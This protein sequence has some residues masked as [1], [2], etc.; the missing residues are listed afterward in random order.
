LSA[1]AREPL[2]V[3]AA[4]QVTGKEVR[5]GDTGLLWGDTL[6]GEMNHRDAQRACDAM[7][8]SSGR[9]EGLKWRLPTQDEGKHVGLKREGGNEFFK[10][11]PDQDDWFWSSSPCS[12]GSHGVWVFYGFSGG[13]DRVSCRDRTLE[14]HVRC[15][16]ERR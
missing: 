7:V 4:A 5:A 8:E 16:A 3:D 13:V 2:P 11:L 15:V 6:D 1:P 14:C 9:T 10:V 12:E